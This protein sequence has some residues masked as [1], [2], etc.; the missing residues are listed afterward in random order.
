NEHLSQG[1]TR[2]NN[3]AILVLEAVEGMD[4]G[5]EGHYAK[6]WTKRGVAA[7]AGAA[8][9][10]VAPAPLGNPANF[11]DTLNGPWIA[12]KAPQVAAWLDSMKG[13]LDLLVEASKRDHY[14]MPLVREQPT[15]PLVM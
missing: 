4:V 2:E 11:D 6:V 7:P 8:Q 10:A 3:A 15:D 9:G 14:Y 1:A 12:E 5:R 13:Q